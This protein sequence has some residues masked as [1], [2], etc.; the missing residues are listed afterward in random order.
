MSLQEDQIEL[1]T[2]DL[3]FDICIGVEEERFIFIEGEEYSRNDLLL[4]KDG[5][6]IGGDR[7]LFKTLTDKS[8]EMIIDILLKYV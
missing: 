4:I 7:T 6:D 1:L 5:K 8:G 3:R 2:M